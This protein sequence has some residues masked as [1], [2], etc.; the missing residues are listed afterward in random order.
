MIFFCIYFLIL[1]SL[2]MFSLISGTISW[3][4]RKDKRVFSNGIEI[5]FT[6]FTLDKN[7]GIVYRVIS[8]LLRHSWE[9]P[10]TLLGNILSQ[11]RNTFWQIDRV[12]LF[13]GVGYSISY[14]HSHNSGISL[15]NF[16]N[17]NT[18]NK[19]I[20]DFQKEVIQ[21]PLLMHE[22]GHTIDSRRFGFLYLFVIGIPSL[23][24]AIRAHQVENQPQGVSSHYYFWCERRANRNAANY[25]SKYFS[26]DWA[27]SYKGYTIETFYKLVKNT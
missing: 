16:I 21:E 20:V 6:N 24:S 26:V 17:V 4:I 2:L 27:T 7:R 18:Y 9:L 13:S 15:G 25:F 22:Y 19:R 1:I 12:E 10:Q 8:L 23:I 14:N 5:F 11:F 3:I